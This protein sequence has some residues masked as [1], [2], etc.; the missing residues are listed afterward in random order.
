MGSLE[1]NL[2]PDQKFYISIRKRIIIID[3]HDDNK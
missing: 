3:Y 2:A 1:I